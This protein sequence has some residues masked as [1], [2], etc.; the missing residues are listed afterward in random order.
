MTV[1]EPSLALSSTPA[2]ASASASASDRLLI[3]VVALK[4]PKFWGD[5]AHVWFAQTKAQFAVRGLTCSLTKFYYYITVL[6]IADAA[7][8]VDL[9]QFPPD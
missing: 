3:H 2:S 7:Q 4:L 8:V 6:G 5:N 1:T 9:I